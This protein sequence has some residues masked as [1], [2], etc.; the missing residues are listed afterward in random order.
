MAWQEEAEPAGNC[1]S[2]PIGSIEMGFDGGLDRDLEQLE[3]LLSCWAQAGRQPLPPHLLLLSL[4]TVRRCQ[5]GCRGCIGGVNATRA[6][7]LRVFLWKHGL[8]LLLVLGVLCA[9][10]GAPPRA[11]SPWASLPRGVK[12]GGCLRVLS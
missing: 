6:Q 9:A 11:G 10:L 7:N 8:A 2:H 12:Q 5:R 4:V 1:F 3:G